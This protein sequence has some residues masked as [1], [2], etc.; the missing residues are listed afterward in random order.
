MNEN[1]DNKGMPN[2]KKAVKCTPVDW[3]SYKIKKEE[4]QPLTL[5]LTENP[6]I[7]REVGKIKKKG[8]TLVGFAAETDHV[9][10]NAADKLKKKNLDMII[11]NDVTLPGAGFNVDTNIATLI[12]AKGKEEQPIQ[13]KRQLAETI[14]ANSTGANRFPGELWSSRKEMLTS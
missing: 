3:D 5:T 12:T 2:G 7:A 8:Q 13:T 1:R 11:A 4:G 10:K 9:L 6:D 14:L